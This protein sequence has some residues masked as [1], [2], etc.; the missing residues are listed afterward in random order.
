MFQQQVTYQNETLDDK[1][2]LEALVFPAEL[3]LVLLARRHGR[4]DELRFALVQRLRIANEYPEV[5]RILKDLQDPDELDSRGN[6]AAV[7]AAFSRHT[8]MLKMLIAAAANVNRTDRSGCTA[9]VAAS[10]SRNVD[11]VQ[12]LLHASADANAVGTGFNFGCLPTTHREKDAAGFNFGVE[13]LAATPLWLRVRHYCQ[14]FAEK[15]EEDVTTCIILRMLAGVGADPNWAPRSN[16][17]WLSVLPGTTPL[18]LAAELGGE[19]LARCL[20]EVWADPLMVDSWSRCPLLVAAENGH[21]RLVTFLISVSADLE[22]VDGWQRT[23]LWTAASQ[24]FANTVATL[25]LAGADVHAAD[26]QGRMPIWTGSASGSAETVRTLLQA[27]ADVDASDSWGA[28]PLCAAAEFGNVE[29]VS[30]LLLARAEVDRADK[31]G[32][33]PM[34]LAAAADHTAVLF[35]LLLA[36]AD[37]EK[38]SN[39][40]AT[41]LL[42]AC[43]CPKG[44]RAAYALMSCGANL[45]KVDHQGRTAWQIACSRVNPD[46][47][48]NV[49]ANALPI[50]GLGWGHYE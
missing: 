4:A 40:G 30:A 8:D 25:L 48:E 32:R 16:E 21:T 10:I 46:D 14:I 31:L 26:N 50:A 37:K 17:C 13:A 35:C 44:L 15:V 43:E 33:T 1:Q 12:V 49:F 22:Q 41:P 24:G 27:R 18:L 29:V 45:G 20:V 39:S 2:G 34:W 23:P 3:Q 19:Q 47:F 28:T 38:A 36:G 6:S 11:A 5:H 7:E 9:L 42:A